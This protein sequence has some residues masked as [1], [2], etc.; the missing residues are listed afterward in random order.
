[1]VEGG[2]EVKSASASGIETFAGGGSSSSKSLG[3]M[4]IENRESGIGD[5]QMRNRMQKRAPAKKHTRM[6]VNLR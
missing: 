4:G 2:G 1:M 5:R 6:E 3:Q